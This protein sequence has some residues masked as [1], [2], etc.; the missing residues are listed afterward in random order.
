MKMVLEWLNEIEDEGIKAE[1][2]KNVIEYGSEDDSFR[3]LS[4]AIL[5][6]MIW[7]RTSQGHEYW[8]DI[9]VRACRGKKL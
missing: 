3:S 5:Y 9:Y 6:G 8:R 7:H 4:G 2:V 1:A